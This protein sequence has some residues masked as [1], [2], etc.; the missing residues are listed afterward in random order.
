MRVIDANSDTTA[1]DEAGSIV[2]RPNTVGGHVIELKKA[3]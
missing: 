3:R 1:F 2:P